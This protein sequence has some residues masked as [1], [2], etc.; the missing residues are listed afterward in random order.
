MVMIRCKLYHFLFT[1]FP[2]KALQG[3]LI[4]NH[5]EDCPDCKDLLLEPDEARTLFVSEDKAPEMDHVWLKI[6]RKLCEE[7]TQSPRPSL[8]PRWK[9]AAGAIGLALFIFVSFWFIPR[10]AELDLNLAADTE[11][12]LQ[13]NYV[14]VEEKPAGAIV[15]EPQDSEMI[16][17]WAE[18]TP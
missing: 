4:K 10:P 13:I 3:F 14:K 6:R 18:R 12:K 15:Y 16:I 7:T 1:V 5:F 9:W 17:V 8:W 2:V 11:Q